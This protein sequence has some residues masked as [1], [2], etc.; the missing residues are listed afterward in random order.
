MSSTT[1]PRGVWDPIQSDYI[2]YSLRNIKA[3]FRVV[4]LRLLLKSIN[5]APA[6]AAH[7]ASK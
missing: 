1:V 7:N 4:G 2:Q 3:C 6:S 5:I